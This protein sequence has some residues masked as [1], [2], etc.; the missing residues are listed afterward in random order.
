VEESVQLSEEEAA[1]V[2]SINEEVT[3]KTAAAE[4]AGEEG[5]VDASIAL[6]KEVSYASPIAVEVVRN[7]IAYVMR[8]GI[9]CNNFIRWRRC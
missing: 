2:A 1:K 9:L 3:A 5:A 8:H 6:M 7:I 4:T